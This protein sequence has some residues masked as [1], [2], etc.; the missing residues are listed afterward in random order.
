MDGIKRVSSKCAA[1]R[2]A[3][4]VDHHRLQK[5]TTLNRKFVKKPVVNHPKV[6]KSAGSQAE[7][8]MI[9]QQQPQQQMSTRQRQMLLKKQ[10]AVQLQPN[11]VAVRKVAQS[12][13]SSQSDA[14]A[15]LDAQ[16]LG[17]TK[18]KTKKF[19]AQQ[20]LR[21]IVARKQANGQKAVEQDLPVQKNAL[22][23]VARARMAARKAPE[24][25]HLSAQELKNRAIEKAMKQMS[26]ANNTDGAV[27]EAKQK[28]QYFWQ[29]K[30]FAVASVMAVLSLALL[31]YLVAL[32]LPDLSVRVAAMQTGI[33]KA[34]PNYVPSSYKLD[35]LVKEDGG[36]LTMAFRNDNNESFTLMEERSS[37][38]SA[39]VLTN[40]VKTNWGEDY[41]VAKGQ[42]LT[43]YIHES[44]AA[45][46]N[47]GVFYVIDGQTANLNS[48]DLHDIAVSL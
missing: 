33:E 47:G 12:K 23:S 15:K 21:Q 28:K 43:I 46:V 25:E 22:L 48:S 2:H 3:S 40:Y 18:Q 20:Q 13:S 32:N 36:R 44:S 38:D 11:T 8:K 37:W 10:Q 4:G 27:V 34:Y 7:R 5:S 35:G 29:K 24:P 41:S 30:R 14:I 16:A 1:T 17:A 9:A 19:S 26:T 45:W 42:G 39:A 31:G 6:V